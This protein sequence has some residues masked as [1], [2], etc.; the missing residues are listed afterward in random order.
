MNG[1]FGLIIVG[2]LGLA[3]FIYFFQR[4]QI[5]K[6]MKKGP[7]MS[8]DVEIK[9]VGDLEDEEWRKEMEEKEKKSIYFAVG[10]L[11]L[12]AII[13]AIVVL[14]AGSFFMALL[15][16]IMNPAALF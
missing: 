12:W 14:T 9:T 3:A 11:I 1:T 15:G 5:S 16:S 8:K 6:K 2:T 13:A 4:H 7:G 10:A